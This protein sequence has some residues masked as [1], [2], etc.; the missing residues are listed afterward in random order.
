[1]RERNAGEDEGGEE[2]ERSAPVPDGT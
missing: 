2:T 1:V